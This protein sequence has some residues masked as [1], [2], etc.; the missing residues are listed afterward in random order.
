MADV[1]LVKSIYTGSNVTSLG[2]VTATDTPVIPGAFSVTGLNTSGSSAW[3]A[4]SELTIAS[5]TVTITQSLHRIDTEG[6]AAI[7]ELDT[8]SGSADG[9]LLAIRAEHADRTVVIKHNTGNIYTD[10]T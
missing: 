2:E 1:K 9:K 3:T 6:D 8:I 5:G 4:A 7:D 10:G